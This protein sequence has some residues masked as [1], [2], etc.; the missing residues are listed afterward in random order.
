MSWKDILKSP[1]IDLA[2]NPKRY[3]DGYLLCANDCIRPVE[4][5]STL[6]AFCGDDFSY[7]ISPPKDFKFDNGPPKGGHKEAPLG[8]KASWISDERRKKAR[9]GYAGYEYSFRKGREEQ[10]FLMDMY[11]TQTPQ[12]IRSSNFTPMECENMIPV[13]GRE[14]INTKCGNILRTQK[15]RE[16]YQCRE[17]TARDEE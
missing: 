13:E 8:F 9:D 1:L 5:D 11:G 17:C 12:D 2:G 10:D 7:R 15:E 3:K 4:E 16:D 14:G 6:C